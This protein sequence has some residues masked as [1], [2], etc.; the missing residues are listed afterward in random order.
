MFSVNKILVSIEENKARQGKTQF[1]YS[2]NCE[3]K[4]IYFLFDI[5]KN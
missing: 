4:V 5:Y 2:N 1:L 3:L